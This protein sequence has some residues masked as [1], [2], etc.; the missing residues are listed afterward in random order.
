MV[1]VCVVSF[2]PVCSMAYPRPGQ[3][4]YWSCMFTDW[5]GNHY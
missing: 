2:V 1:P 3:H 5:N 4:V